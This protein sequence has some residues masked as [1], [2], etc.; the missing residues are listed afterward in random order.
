MSDTGASPSQTLQFAC[1]CR[2]NWGHIKFASP[3]TPR[4]G[5][6]CH[7]Y[8]CRHITGSLCS[9]AISKSTTPF[10]IEYG[11]TGPRGFLSMW[12]AYTAVVF[13]SHCGSILSWQN[14]MEV[15]AIYTGILRD[16]KGTID[17]QDQCCV[18]ETGDGG[19]SNWLDLPKRTSCPI[20]RGL[21]SKEQEVMVL[22]REEPDT[23]ASCYCRNICF[24]ITPPNVSSTSPSSPFSDLIVPYH[25]GPSTNSADEKWWLRAN[26]TKYFAGTC[27]CQSCRLASGNDI[28]TWAFV[29]K[30]NIRKSNGE[31]FDFSM[32]QLKRYESS[33]GVY[34]RFCSGCGAI[35]FWHDETRPELIDVAVGLLAAGSGARAEELLEW[36]TE[37]VSF[38]EDAQNKDLIAK[39]G[40]GIRAWA[41]SKTPVNSQ[42]A[43]EQ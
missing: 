9:S 3:D 39:L 1:L 30:V 18:L 25:S 28:Q 11:G 6:L 13:C 19:L 27:A 32:A 37:R 41:K 5:S 38:Q 20:P 12:A 35:V 7:C 40:Q 33:K 17:F 42:A 4:I 10:T 8:I 16:P 23:R 21:G 29:P 43:L 26:G 31:P 36:A 14:E 15:L 34:R 22:P 24:Q 2:K